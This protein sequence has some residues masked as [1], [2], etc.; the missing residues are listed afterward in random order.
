MLVGTVDPHIRLPDPLDLRIGVSSTLARV[1]RKSGLRF[2]A[3]RWRKARRGNPQD[4]ADRLDPV[5]VAM[6]CP[7]RHSILESAVDLRLGKKSAG[8]LQYLVGSAQLLDFALQFL[9][10]RLPCRNNA[11]AHVAIACYALDPFVERLRHAAN[12]WCDRCNGRP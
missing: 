1:Q 11:V 4:F 2:W 9:H 8:Q 6:L 10:T 7:Q 3:A 5:D 12:L